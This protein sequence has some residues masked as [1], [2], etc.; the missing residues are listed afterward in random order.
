MEFNGIYV[1]HELISK[2]GSVLSPTNLVAFMDA[3][4]NDINDINTFN[5]IWPVNTAT[6]FDQLYA[7]ILVNSA[8]IFAMVHSHNSNIS[9]KSN[10]SKFEFNM[11]LNSAVDTHSV[12]IIRILIE[13]IPVEKILTD[14]LH[15]CGC[16]CTEIFEMLLKKLQNH[17]NKIIDWTYLRVPHFTLNKIKILHEYV[18]MCKIITNAQ[19]CRLAHE[20]NEDVFCYLMDICIC[21]EYAIYPHT[22][23][24]TNACR[25]VID[26]YDNQVYNSIIEEGGRSPTIVRYM[27]QCRAYNLTDITDITGITDITDITLIYA[28]CTP[29]TLDVMVEFGMPIERIT[30]LASQR[31]L[32]VID[33]IR[34]EEIIDILIWL[35]EKGID[36]NMIMTSI[37]RMRG[38]C[39]ELP[40]ADTVAQLIKKYH[41]DISVDILDK[42]LTSAVNRGD[43]NL[44]KILINVVGISRTLHAA[45][46][47]SDYYYSKV[48]A[49]INDHYGNTHQ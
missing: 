42:L 47:H 15:I 19:M 46:N 10:I 48:S 30:T 11:L 22:H 41:D 23:E 2:I 8:K 34:Y 18:S 29:E 37:C 25:R 20:C 16:G 45:V 6:T 40:I 49:V 5:E 7:C 32:R 17:P 44:V 38:E 31:I 3:C 14:H 33:R 1:P 36:V 28:L 24:R 26:I 43:V 21:N 4:I 39:V 9:E 13:N 35:V 27:L 12:D